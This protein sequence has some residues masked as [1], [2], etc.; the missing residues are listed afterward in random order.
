MK[1]LVSVIQCEW[2]KLRNSNMLFVS[3]LGAMVTPFMMAVAIMKERASNP[4]FTF[5]YYSI[6]AQ[7]NFYLILLFGLVVY[8]VFASFLYSR[9]YTENTLKMLITIPISKTALMISK[10]IVLLIWCSLLSLLS[11]LFCFIISTIFGAVELNLFIITK[12]I[13]EYMI[14]TVLL[15]GTLTP[16]IFL[17]IWSK[18]IVIPVI[19]SATLLMMNAAL[20]NE[21]IAALFP[22]SAIY[23][24]VT[25]QIEKTGY[26]M[27][28]AF[29][30]IVVVSVLGMGLSLWY[31]GKNDVK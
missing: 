21:N 26:K 22:W 4:D 23:L 27:E 3:I 24:V 19:T 28:V 25:N 12:S 17:S 5:T 9:E 7:S 15:I 11:W 16:M 29:L 8:T 20:S 6:F 14:S 2:L 30:I 31:F 13:W 18:G 1:S 10:F